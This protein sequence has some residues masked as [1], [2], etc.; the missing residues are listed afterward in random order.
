VEALFT[1]QMHCTAIG[2]SRDLSG[3]SQQAVIPMGS[4]R[5]AVFVLDIV[6]TTEVLFDQR[7]FATS[8]IDRYKFVQA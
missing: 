7:T 8:A 2:H 6:V 5:P 1:A 4:K 3:V